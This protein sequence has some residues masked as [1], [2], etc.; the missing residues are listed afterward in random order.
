MLPLIIQIARSKHIEIYLV[1]F[2]VVTIIN[3]IPL[4]LKTYFDVDIQ[5]YIMIPLMEWQLGCLILGY[6]IDSITINL[7]GF[8]ISI[9]IF[10]CSGWFMVYSTYKLSLGANEYRRDFSSNE[11]IFAIAMAVCIFVMI[12]Y[13]SKYVE[14]S[15]IKTVIECISK[16]TFFIYLVHPLVI[17]LYRGNVEVKVTKLFGI[18]NKLAI[19][20]IFSWCVVFFVSYIAAEIIKYVWMYLYRFV[21][22]RK[23][24]NGE[25]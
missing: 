17:M 12:K 1:C 9:V 18:Y 16:R 15:F 25:S 19:R 3:I 2:A 23:V 13:V 20:E 21:S 11:N 4:I 7:K 14:K 8:I 22:I 5:I 10:V 6:V 24:N